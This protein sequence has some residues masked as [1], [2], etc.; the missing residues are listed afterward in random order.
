LAYGHGSLHDGG[1]G[2]GT[3]RVLSIHGSDGARTWTP[4]PAFAKP[5]TAAAV[6]SLSREHSPDSTHPPFSK[7]LA[8]LG[9]TGI[10]EVDAVGMSA[11]EQLLSRDTANDLAARF[12]EEWR[13]KAQAW[14]SVGR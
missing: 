3:G 9:Y 2:H 5:I 8:N 7:R 11:T 10:P 6:A 1:A 13:K 14:V 12:D 4:A